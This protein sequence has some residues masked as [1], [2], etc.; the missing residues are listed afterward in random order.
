VK[1]PKEMTHAELVYALKTWNDGPHSCCWELFE[2]LLEKSEP[3]SWMD[4]VAEARSLYSA[5]FA[6]GDKVQQGS[7]MDDFLCYITAKIERNTLRA[8]ARML[9]L[10][11][12][13]YD[14]FS[15]Y[16]DSWIGWEAEPGPPNAQLLQQLAVERLGDRDEDLALTPVAG[17]QP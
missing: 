16:V 6:D 10:P 15:S 17:E 7:V 4:V 3:S 1:S 9:G 11:D 12:E 13:Q 8:V 14:E 2:Q 5:M